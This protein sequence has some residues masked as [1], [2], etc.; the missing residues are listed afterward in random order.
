MTTLSDVSGKRAVVIGGGKTGAAAARLLLQRGARV[1]VVDDAP[2]EKV[3]A[4]LEKNGLRLDRDAVDVHAGG[5]ESS[6]VADADLAVLSPGVPR[7]H[8]ALREAL[9]KGVPVVNEVE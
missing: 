5:I 8:K 7:A 3:V 6:L 1:D 4:G 9:S 2:L